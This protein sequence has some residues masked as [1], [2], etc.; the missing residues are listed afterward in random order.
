MNLTEIYLSHQGKVSQKFVS[1]L[2]TYERF[3]NTRKNSISSILE[4]GVQNGGSL[5]IW[6]KYFDKTPCIVGVDINP[7]CSNL[8]F[9]D[10]RIKFVLGSTLEQKTYKR[11]AEISPTYDL[12]IDDGSHFATDIVSNFLLYYPLLKEG[13]LFIVEGMHASYWE[14][15]GGGLHNQRAAHSFFKLLTDAMHREHYRPEDNAG[16]LF[17]TWMKSQSMSEFINANPIYSVTFLDSLVIIE[18]TSSAH[19][20]GLGDVVLAGEEAIVESSI[21]RHR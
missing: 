12:I 20:G 15:Y 1:Y 8:R 13:G 17:Q 9:D 6:A 21:L 10:S 18:K 4:I 5:E 7:A 16:R 2:T 14:E 19:P 3:L 11:I